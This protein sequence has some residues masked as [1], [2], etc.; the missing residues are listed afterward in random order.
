MSIVIR[1]TAQA[2]GAQGHRIDIYTAAPAGGLERVVQLG[3]NVR[4][5][6]LDHK[7]GEKIS[8]SALFSH[9]PR[10]YDALNAFVAAEDA[11]YDLLHSHYWLSARM[12][13]WA[14]KKWQVPHVVT[15]HTLGWLKNRFGPHREETDQRID[16]E[17]RIARTC[18]RLLVATT[19][20]KT[21]LV[22]QFS[23]AGGR[24]GVVPFGV[25]AAT[26]DIKS[27]R[28][29]RERVGLPMDVRVVL[30]VG[31]FAAVKG[32]ER[33][34]KAVALLDMPEDVRLL[35]IGGDGATSASTRKLMALARRLG[36]RRKVIIPGR[37]EHAALVNYYNAADVVAVPSYY[38]SFG[39]VVL[40][41][42]AC[43]TPVVANPVGVV[44]SVVMD[45]ENGI[46][47]QDQMA[48]G[49]ADALHRVLQGT[50]TGRIRP[51]SVRSTVMDYHWPVVAGAVLNQYAIAADTCRR[52]DASTI[53][54]QS[55]KP[56][57]GK[58]ETRDA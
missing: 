4:L 19:A 11:T 51:R 12:G 10:Y 28:G 5:I 30:F 26:F 55:S 58:G 13:G 32:I 38:E 35:L 31:R 47:V 8:K 20:E 9:L 56:D 21:A 34:M 1:E 24:V 43:G 42:L 16:W 7:S 23:L 40:E 48:A 53:G 49:I 14:Q 45:G 6:H 41:A 25:D 44:P 29:A 3:K 22:E 18:H 39:L 33:L 2:L 50:A 36:I 54:K 27:M 37:I 46:V 57:P 17:Y 52:C 15:F